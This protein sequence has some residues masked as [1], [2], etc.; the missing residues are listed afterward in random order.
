MKMYDVIVPNSEKETVKLDDYNADYGLFLLFNENDDFIGVVTFNDTS[1]TYQI[2]TATNG[3][4]MYRN[5]NTDNIVT[6][7]NTIK[8]AFP[9]FYLKYLK[10]HNC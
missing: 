7:Y 6:F 8:E 9:G 3:K 10:T 4:P 2:E 1:R 5:Y